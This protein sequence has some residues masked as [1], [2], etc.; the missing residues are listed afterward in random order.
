[1][2]FIISGNLVTVE[3]YQS[4][5]YLEARLQQKEEEGEENEEEVEK[6]RSGILCEDQII[7]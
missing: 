3:N 5:L 4:D 2:Y 6:G 7:N 1:M